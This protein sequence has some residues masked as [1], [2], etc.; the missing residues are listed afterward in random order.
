MDKRGHRF[1]DLGVNAGIHNW[2][3]IEMIVNTKLVRVCSSAYLQS[4]NLQDCERRMRYE[5]G[6]T[7][8]EKSILG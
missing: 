1:H 7:N 5:I 2:K 4:S 3:T 8:C 6:F